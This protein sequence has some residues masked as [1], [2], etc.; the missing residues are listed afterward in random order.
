M[1]SPRIIDVIMTVHRSSYREENLLE[2]NILFM[3]E[4]HELW[5]KRQKITF[6]RTMMFMQANFTISFSEE[7]QWVSSTAGFSDLASWCGLRVLRIWIECET[8]GVSWRGKFIAL[9]KNCLQNKH[10]GRRCRM[11]HLLLILNRSQDWWDLWINVP[12]LSFYMVDPTKPINYHTV[13]TYHF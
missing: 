2:S 6:K 3:K 11:L 5:L 1:I 9:D 7:H 10:Y 8:Y 12:R 4:H 13:H